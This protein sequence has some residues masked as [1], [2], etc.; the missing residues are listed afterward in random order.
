MG[1]NSLQVALNSGELIRQAIMTSDR[2][3]NV[4]KPADILIGETNYIEL[5]VKTLSSAL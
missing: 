3:I 1:Y 5:C 2:F 4:T